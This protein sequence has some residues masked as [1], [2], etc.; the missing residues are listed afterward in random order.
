MSAPI[1]IDASADELR[2]PTCGNAGDQGEI[3]YLV[4]GTA[5]TAVLALAAGVLELAGPSP[6]SRRGAR[7]RLECWALRSTNSQSVCR[8]QWDLPSGII[9][10]TWRVRS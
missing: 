8:R 7:P 10:I 3:R 4:D 9:G 5:R 1:A 2:C 6:S